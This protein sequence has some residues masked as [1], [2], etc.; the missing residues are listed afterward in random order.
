MSRW[1]KVVP[2]QQRIKERL[3]VLL[4]CKLRGI[5]IPKCEIVEAYWPPGIT[6]IGL[7][8]SRFKHLLL[9]LLANL[10][11]KVATISNLFL[12]MNL[13]LLLIFLS[14]KETFN[15][16]FSKIFEQIFS[17]IVILKVPKFRQAIQ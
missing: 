8:S 3:G 10:S 7:N 2:G 15:L 5:K 13:L 12:M 9:L 1:F 6:F 17:L 4:K 16:I 14:W 11:L